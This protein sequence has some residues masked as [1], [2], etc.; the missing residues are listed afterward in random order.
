MGRSSVVLSVVT[1][2]A[3]ALLP[4]SPGIAVD[5]GEL[6]SLAKER[7]LGKFL[8]IAEGSAWLMS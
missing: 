5:R 6:V 2:C 3:S 1:T 4:R 8:P 7:I